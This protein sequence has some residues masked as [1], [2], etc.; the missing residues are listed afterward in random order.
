MIRKAKTSYYEKIGNK[1]CDPKTGQKTY[2]TAFK[3]I[4]NKKKY[5]NIPPLIGQVHFISN[6]IQKAQIFN[7]YFAGQCKIYDNGSV[8]PTL[9][10][11]TDKNLVNIDITELQIVNIIMKLNPNKSHGYEGISIAMLQLCSHEIANPL[12]II[13]QHSLSAGCFPDNCKLAN[14]QPIHKKGSRQQKTNYRPISL[15]PICGKILE[16]IVF[17]SVYHFLNRNNQLSKNQSGFRPGDSTINQLLSI[18]ADMFQSFENYH[19]TR[20]IFLDISKA[21][22]KVWH[23]GLIGK[24]KSNGISGSLLDFFTNY[25]SDRYQRI[26][27]NGTESNWVKLTA[28]VPQASVLGPL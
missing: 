24:L 9:R 4:V 20:A 2:W 7:E 26:V 25:L 6:F 19:E 12:K 3:K 22:D 1:L 28:G 13:F 27:L 21:F 17:D 18:T 23:E 10:K 14:V 8:L 15:L 5:T 16:K 11:R